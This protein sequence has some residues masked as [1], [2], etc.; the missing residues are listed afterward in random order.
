MHL[1]GCQKILFL[2]LFS[3]SFLCNVVKECS[4]LNGRVPIETED[5][6]SLFM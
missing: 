2:V 6:D 4:V 5:S 3:N 1:V